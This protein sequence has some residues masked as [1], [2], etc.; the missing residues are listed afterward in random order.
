MLDAQLLPDYLGRLREEDAL[1]GRAFAT[2]AMDTPAPSAGEQ[3]QTQRAYLE[4]RLATA[5]G[6][7]EGTPR[8]A[9]V[10]R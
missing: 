7:D 4:F 9:G 6:K 2:L 3:A 8:A 10:P 5:P 1:R